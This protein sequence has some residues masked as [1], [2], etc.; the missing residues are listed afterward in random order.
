MELCMWNHSKPPGDI[1]K[2]ST[3][4]EWSDVSKC[5]FVQVEDVLSVC[6]EL[7]LNKQL[8]PNRY[9]TGNVCVLV[10]SEII[11]TYG[12]YFGCNHSYVTCK[13]AVFWCVYRA[14]CTVYFPDQNTHKQYIYIYIDNILYT[15]NTPTCFDAPATSSGNFI[16]LLCLSHP[17]TRNT[18]AGITTRWQSRLHIQPPS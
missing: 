3:V 9:G 11:H 1:R 4:K 10:A 17:N 16:I 2:D 7:W 18:N 5:A 13:A 15:V 12:M 8:E 6:F 14:S